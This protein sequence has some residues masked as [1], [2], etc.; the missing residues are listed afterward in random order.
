MHFAA[1]SPTV[2]GTYSLRVRSVAV[3]R[4]DCQPLIGWAA[5][6]TKAVALTAGRWPELRQ[7]Y[8]PLP[9]PHLYEHPNS[10][11]SLV[12]E[13]DWKGERAIFGD[14]ISG[15]ENLSLREIDDRL[16]SMKGAQ[17]ETLGGFR[18]IIRITGY[19]LPVRRLLWNLVL[20]GS[21]R[22]RA[23]YFGTFCVNLLAGRRMEISQSIT[24]HA[25]SLYYR[26]VQPDGIMKLHLYLDHRVIDGA[27]AARWLADLETTLNRDIVA[28]L[29]GELRTANDP[30][31]VR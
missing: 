16:R 17:I 18:R 7:C 25:I 24:L 23:R 26:P 4:R 8:M 30:A 22:L 29:N 13:R 21:G 5:I 31:E 19:P 3:A 14:Q 15:P 1:A 11:A 10:V 20:K 12:V 28:E 27:G 9:W 6:L 2:G